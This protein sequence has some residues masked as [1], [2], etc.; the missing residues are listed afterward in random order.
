MLYSKLTFGVNMLALIDG[1]LFPLSRKEREKRGGR[2]GTPWQKPLAPCVNIYA[3]IKRGSD[4]KGA[5]NA[6]YYRKSVLLSFRDN[7]DIAMF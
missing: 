7:V 4:L 2:N 1:W 5:L 6:F 3:I